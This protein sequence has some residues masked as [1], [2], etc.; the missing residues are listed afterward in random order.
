M[1]ESGETCR[2]FCQDGRFGYKDLSR[3]GYERVPHPEHDRTAR[4]RA[5]TAPD[6]S[7]PGC[8]RPVATACDQSF[9]PLLQALLR[10]AAENTV[11]LHM[12]GH[13]G[14]APA[15]GAFGDDLDDLEHLVGEK[16]FLADVTELPGLDDLH[17]AEGPIKEAQRL[18]ALAYGADASFFLVNGSTCGIH[19]MI[20]A[21][22]GAGDE[23]IVPRDAHRAVVGGLVLSG[24]RPVYVASEVDELFGVP[25][26][27]TPESLKSA[28]EAHPHARAVMLTNP[29]YYGVAPEIK[30]LVAMAHDYG[31]IALVDEAHGAHLPF[32]EDLP[33]SALEA[34]A[35]AVVSGAHKGLPAMTQASLLHLKG[36][37]IDREAISRALRLIETTS[38]SYVLMASI[39]AARRI[40]AT[41]GRE[42]L[43]RVIRLAGEAREKL[44][45]SPGVRCLHERD[46][47]PRGFRHDPTKLLISLSGLGMTGFEA[48]GILRR[49]HGVQVELA[50]DGN[51]L[52]ILTIMDSEDDVMALVSAVEAIARDRRGRGGEVGPESR[53]EAAAGLS[54][55]LRNAPHLKMTPREAA[56]SPVD[57]VDLDA[58]AGR[59]ASDAVV[60]YPP[61]IPLVCPGEEITP[62]IVEFACRALSSG[63]GLQGVSGGRVPVVARRLKTFG[64]V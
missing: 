43:D 23:I 37:R 10:Y 20:M 12:P 54:F 6:R 38:P 8:D 61:G 25:L 52:A 14:R 32:H 28:L 22:C 53:R 42:L 5:T 11:R 9:A 4:D 16:V 55:A 30:T 59:V 24:A 13:K 7:A 1:Q 31:K 18:A 29:N 19:A 36:S 34:G 51:V 58:A 44:D 2:N 57:W 49:E 63:V 50:D 40:A 33:P 35:D 48:A 15:S 47:A 56:F 17:A 62:A 26:G 41:R 60:P 3:S 46:L 27:P 39:D 64:P 21:S 45:R